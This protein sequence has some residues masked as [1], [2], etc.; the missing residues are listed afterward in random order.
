MATASAFRSPEHLSDEALNGEICE[1]QTP[2]KENAA[3]G[4]LPSKGYPMT[5]NSREG[6]FA[7]VTRVTTPEKSQGPMKILQESNLCNVD[8]VHTPAPTISAKPICSE[9]VDKKTEEIQQ[10]AKDT[11]Q[12]QQEASQGEQEAGTAATL[13]E[14][15]PD[16]IVSQ[17]VSLVFDQ[18]EWLE[19]VV[20]KYSLPSP[21]HVI[22]SLMRKANSEPPKTKRLIFLVIRCRRCLQHQK[23]GTKQDCTLELTS[24]QWQWLEMIRNCSRHSSVDKTLRIIADFYMPL[25][26][27]D[28]AFERLILTGAAA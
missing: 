6:A 5:E 24:Q 21:S 9:D 1:A 22:Q 18:I 13:A 3:P 11:P 23:G 2:R 15:Q 17:S 4:V 8:L 20:A 12:G 25:F 10:P 27:E 14:K 16:E 26:K 28:E 7:P 19:E